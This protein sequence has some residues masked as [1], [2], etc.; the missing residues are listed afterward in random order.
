MRER[1]ISYMG[2][3]VQ[4]F[5]ASFR[6]RRL[7]GAGIAPC[8]YELIVSSPKPRM[9]P[10]GLLTSPIA[11]PKCDYLL[12]TDRVV[13]SSVGLSR[14]VQV[15]IQLGWGLE[16]GHAGP[17]TPGARTEGYGPAFCG[18][19]LVPLDKLNTSQQGALH[20]PLW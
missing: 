15:R 17:A 4:G 13:G 16:L 20:T 7:G 6:S 19:G 8:S 14:S 12:G 5:S 2:T 1:L 3:E 9:T 11:G 10:K 18:S